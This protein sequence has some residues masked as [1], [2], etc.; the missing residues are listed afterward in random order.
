MRM[1]GEPRCWPHGTKA[2]KGLSCVSQHRPRE[3]KET[4]IWG[5]HG[6]EGLLTVQISLEGPEGLSV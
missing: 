5:E 6:K 2:L 3:L 1:W 4:F